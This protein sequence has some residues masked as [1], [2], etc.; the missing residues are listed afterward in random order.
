MSSKERYS[1]N[2]VTFWSRLRDVLKFL[3]RLIKL[4]ERYLQIYDVFKTS[5]VTIY[6]IFEILFWDVFKTSYLGSLLDI[7]QQSRA[8]TR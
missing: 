1:E 4:S 6:D 7:S 5:Y 3:R 2:I 8:E